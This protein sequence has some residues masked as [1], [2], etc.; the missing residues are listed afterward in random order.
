[1]QNFDGPTINSDIL[2]GDNKCIENKE[3][4]QQGELLSDNHIFNSTSQIHEKQAPNELAR[5]DPALSLAQGLEVIQ[6]NDWGP[7]HLVAVRHRT[8]HHVAHFLVRQILFKQ[9]RD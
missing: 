4:R 5:N 1:M 2:T 8:Q 3:S 6:F 9:Q 7:Q